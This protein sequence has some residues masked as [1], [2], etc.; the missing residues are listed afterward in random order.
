MA[1][2]DERMGKQVCF[3]LRLG[4]ERY[5]FSKLQVQYAGNCTF[6]H[7]EHIIRPVRT[8]SL[9]LLLTQSSHSFAYQRTSSRPDN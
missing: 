4:I 8:G 1:N 3:Q 2:T 9:V 5:R 6:E 7:F